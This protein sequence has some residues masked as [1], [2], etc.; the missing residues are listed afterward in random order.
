MCLARTHV[1][2][3][4][5]SGRLRFDVEPEALFLEGSGRE[6]AVDCVEH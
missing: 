5:G 1:L 3:A 4:I 2:A 6:A